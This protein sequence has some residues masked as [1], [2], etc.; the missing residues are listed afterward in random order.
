MAAISILYKVAIVVSKN[1]ISE[2]CTT[3]SLV[4]MVMM[5]MMV[6]VMVYERWRMTNVNVMVPMMVTVMMVIKNVTMVMTMVM[7]M[8]V[9]VVMVTS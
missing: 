3:L 6:R 1:V 5:G 4:V 8:M 2:N 9:T 7:A